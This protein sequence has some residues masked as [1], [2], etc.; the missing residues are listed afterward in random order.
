MANAKRELEY[1]VAA[2]T[3]KYFGAAWSGDRDGM[4]DNPYRDA[5][6]VKTTEQLESEKQS[7]WDLLR[8]GMKNL[9]SI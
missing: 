2:A 9:A 7:G 8:A 4:R 3:I 6:V 1:D 5:D